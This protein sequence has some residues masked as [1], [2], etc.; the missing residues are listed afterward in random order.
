MSDQRSN[1]IV[2]YMG[3]VRALA[4]KIHQK[5]PRQIDLE[6]LVGYGTIG[7]A[8]AATTFDP[9]RGY[10]FTT[11]AFHRIRGAILDGLSKMSWFRIEKYHDGSYRP[12]KGV[13][14]YGAEEETIPLSELEMPLE[15]FRQTAERLESQ[16]LTALS[17]AQLMDAEDKG[18]SGEGEAARR[19]VQD[20]VR[21][22]VD[23]LPATAAELL[24]ATYYEGLTLKDAAARM[25]RNKTWASRLHAQALARLGRALQ[26]EGLG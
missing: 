16:R 5:L 18:L 3:L 2:N 23:A 25:G 4:W 20:R 7:L 9:A 15:W 21:Q 11:Y 19:E 17:S 12:D 22:L 13:A 1:L 8:E 14:G 24:R 10:R 6:D 26:R